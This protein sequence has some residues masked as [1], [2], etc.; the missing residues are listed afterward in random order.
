MSKALMVL[1]CTSDAGKSMLATAL[2]RIFADM[3]LKVAPF[4]PQNMALN[5]AVTEDL[6]EI[7]RAQATQA[8]AAR[9]QPHTDMNPVLL[10]PTTDMGSQVIIQGKAIGHYSARDFHALKPT[11]MDPIL[12]SFDRLRAQNDLVIVEGAGSPAEINLRA[13]DLANMGFAEAA[14][15]PCLLM[16]DID[17]GG[18]FAH[19]TGTLAC[20]SDSEQKRIKGLIINKFRGDPKLLDSGL[21][22]LAQNTG[23]PSWGVIPLLQDLY[24]EAEDSLSTATNQVRESKL[25][26]RVARLPKMSNHTDFDPLF[27]HPE[28]DCQWAPASKPPE[29]CDLLILPGSKSVQNDLQALRASGWDTALARHLRYGGKLLGVCGGYQMLGR[30]LSDP[31]GIEGDAKNIDGFGWLNIASQLEPHKALKRVGGKT[32]GDAPVVGYEIHMGQSSGVDCARAWINLADGPDGAASEDGQVL[33]TYVHG[34]FDRPEALDAIMHWAGVELDQRH[35]HMAVI[36]KNITALA[37]HVA[38]HIDM[39]AICQELDITG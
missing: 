7:G 30:T 16:A 21:D 17:K 1:G 34:L 2:C 27:L 25:K 5:S 39:A 19:L 28:L 35:D 10:K 23:K 4:K 36:E 12:E 8:I 6:G 38:A 24:L 29:P 11:L 32:F 33:G 31:L 15:V 13:N 14:D 37:R 18:V 3:G 9:I 22:W 20:L 26:I